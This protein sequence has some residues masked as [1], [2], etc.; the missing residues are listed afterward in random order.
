MPSPLDILSLVY[1]VKMYNYNIYYQNDY[2]INFY[3]KK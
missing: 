3:S 2:F 1:I